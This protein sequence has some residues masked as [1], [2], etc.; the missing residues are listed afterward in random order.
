MI[1]IQATLNHLL[2]Q[3]TETKALE[4]KKA[5]NTYDFIKSGKY[6]SAFFEYLKNCRFAYFVLIF[7]VKKSYL[8]F[9]RS[10]FKRT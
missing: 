2:S 6:S 5:N 8:Y 4:L 1:D 3:G 7:H 10:K 9:K